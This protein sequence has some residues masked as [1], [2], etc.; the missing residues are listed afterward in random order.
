MVLAFSTSKLGI[1][2][3]AAALLESTKNFTGSDKRAEDRTITRMMA[4]MLYLPD[5]LI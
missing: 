1:S 3:A 4:M 2:S 5:F